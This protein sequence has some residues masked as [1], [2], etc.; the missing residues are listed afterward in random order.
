MEL[1]VY[2]KFLETCVSHLNLCGALWGEDECTQTNAS[3]KNEALVQAACP[4]GDLSQ[5]Q[6]RAQIKPKVDAKPDAR[7]TS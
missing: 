5:N 6:V 7:W 4:W 1:Q 3:K 2:R